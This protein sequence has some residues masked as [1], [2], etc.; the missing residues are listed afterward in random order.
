MMSAYEE[1]NNISMNLTEQSGH[2]VYVLGS[3]YWGH[4]IIVNVQNT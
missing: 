2:E 4:F 3:V 1:N